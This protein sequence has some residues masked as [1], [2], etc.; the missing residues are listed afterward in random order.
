MIENCHL[1]KEVKL[2][3]KVRKTN[4][5]ILIETIGGPLPPPSRACVT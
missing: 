4:T 1:K 2:K 3:I 5:G